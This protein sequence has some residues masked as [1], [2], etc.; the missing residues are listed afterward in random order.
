MDRTELATLIGTAIKNARS[1]R[2]VTQGTLA[3]ALSIEQSSISGFEIGRT[4]PTVERLR[5][6]EQALEAEPGSLTRLL[7]FVP[8]PG[9]EVIPP[10]PPVVPPKDVHQQLD[11]LRQ[12]MSAIAQ[13][14]DQL[15][16]VDRPTGP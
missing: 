16:G 15:L 5:Q 2:G 7:G 12:K 1:A 3:R 6:I 13:A 9:T 11:E 10:V 14:V 4:L 8:V